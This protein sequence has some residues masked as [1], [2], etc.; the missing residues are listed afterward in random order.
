MH[1]EKTYAAQTLGNDPRVSE[2]FHHLRQAIDAWEQIM[3]RPHKPSPEV[4]VSSPVERRKVQDGLRVA[5][6]L[7]HTIKEVLDILGISRSTLYTLL[8]QGDLKAVKLGKRT[9]IL[10]RDLLE[11]LDRLPP[12]S[13]RHTTRSVSP[14]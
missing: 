6:K 7:A 2:L 8:G 11:W 5:P 13:G 1:S 4:R 3:L 14:R 9:L 10:N 12:T